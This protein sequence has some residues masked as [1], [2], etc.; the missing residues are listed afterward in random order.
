V[1]SGSSELKAGAA[2]PPPLAPRSESEV[3]STW[4][5]SDAPVVSILCPTFNQRAYLRDAL[6]GMLGQV[7]EHAFEVIVRDDASTDG[8]TEIVREFAERFPRILRPVIESNNQFSRGVSFIPPLAVHARGEFVALCAGD[9]YW[10]DPS[11]LDQ[12]ITLLK[13]RPDASCSFHSAATCRDGVV[14]KVSATH[15]PSAPGDVSARDLCRGM[16]PFGLVLR[17][18][19]ADLTASEYHGSFC[20]DLLMSSQLGCRGSAAYLEGPPR[21]VYRLHSSNLWTTKSRA[22]Q[23]AELCQSLARISLF[24]R[25]RGRRGVAS[26]Y[27]R[28]A[29]KT[30][31][32]LLGES[33]T[34]TRRSI[35]GWMLMLEMLDLLRLKRLPSHPTR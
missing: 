16:L 21:M 24:H 6:H 4:R 14:L 22:S 5:S 9:D 31:L 25:R 23:L 19:A 13:R 12:Q 34:R 20:E 26:Y 10:T 30:A 28:R 7:T 33:G 18:S 35:S 27:A 1:T 11:K 8:T 29:S 3:M 17:S 15:N 32:Q 2:A